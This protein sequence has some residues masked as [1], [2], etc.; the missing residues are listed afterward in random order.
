MSTIF[1]TSRCQRVAPLVLAALLQCATGLA[2]D[3]T[4]YPVESVGSVAL[5]PDGAIWFSSV[6][7]IG[8]IDTTGAIT[9]FPTSTGQNLALT[10]GSDG[11]LWFTAQ[12]RISR[13]TTSGVVTEFPLP[14]V[15]GTPHDITS[16]PDGNL[17]F[18]SFAANH[19]GRITTSGVI[20]GFPLP[21]VAAFPARITAGADGNLWFT[22]Y[23][24]QKIG[25]IT[26]DGII[27]EFALPRADN[28]PV[29]IAAGPD[30]NLWFTGQ[31][32]RVGR[33]TPTGEVTEF[34]VSDETYDV[35][36]GT[37]GNL[38]FVGWGEVSRVTTSG[39]VTTFSGIPTYQPGGMA[40]SPDGAIWIAGRHEENSQILRF[41]LEHAE[42]STRR[43]AARPG[44]CLADTT[45]LCLHNG[46]FHVTADWRNPD[47][48][49]GK[50]RG[51]ALTSDSGYFWFFEA[52]NVELV[53]K[54]LDGCLSGE[55]YW[56]FAAGL[57]NVEV[58]T[59][60][61]DTQ[62][63]FSKTYTNPLGTPFAPIQDTSTFSTC[64]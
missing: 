58:T 53:V 45:T 15:L 60:V 63:G 47:G 49:N 54:V 64:P 21:T 24:A 27:T 2:Q 11:N 41:A 36:A 18:T 19:V 42:R 12:G 51:V 59:T 8:R 44:S 48:A 40:V 17:W 55:T 50:G 16:G 6:G 52:A 28:F 13:M 25:R 38:W 3:I 61:T 10:F 4:V 43:R 39:A 20:T 5:G 30:G 35:A 29:G 56:F 31:V 23:T 62:T 46:R 14:N 33:I 57:T 1:A 9:E 26:T 34:P 7:K 22:E 32:R 37:D